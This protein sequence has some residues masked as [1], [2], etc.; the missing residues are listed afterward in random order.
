MIRVLLC[1]RTFQEVDRF[2]DLEQELRVRGYS[3]IWKVSGSGFILTFIFLFFIFYYDLFIVLS[4]ALFA[5]A[6]K[7][8]Y[9]PLTR[10]EMFILFEN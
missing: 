9:L 2:Q 10:F 7:L 3:G 4:C 6:V 1:D 5:F 8:L